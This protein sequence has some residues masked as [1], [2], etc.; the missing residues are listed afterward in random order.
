MHVAIVAG[1]ASGDILGAGLIRS[2]K[3]KYPEASFE[4][5]A[6]PL[7]QAEGCKSFFSME[8]LAVMG[9]FNVLLRVP[10]L[11]LLRLQLIKRWKKKPPDLFI[12]IDAPEFNTGLELQLKKHGILTCH[13]VSPSV[14]AWRSNRIHKIKQAVDL[15]LVLFPFEE[16]FYLDHHLRVSCVGHPLADQIPLENDKLLARSKLNISE[17]DQVLAVL[18]GSRMSE[19]KML[20]KLFFEVAQ[21]CRDKLPEL[22]IIVPCVNEKIR[23]ELQQYEAQIPGLTVKYFDSHQ[24][25]KVMIASDSVL[26]AS[27]TATL[28]A[29]LLKKPMVV[30]YKVSQLTY[31]LAKHLVKIDKFAIPNL[32][33]KKP[34]VPE[35]IQDEANPLV[36][37]DSVLDTFRQDTTKDTIHAFHNVHT[38]LKRNADQKAAE[39]ISCLLEEKSNENCR[40]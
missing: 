30:A 4:G 7:M 8:K 13:Y 6:G 24:N 19:V 36:I 1:E 21:L 28:E 31:M 26:L 18:P 37:A 40:C 11:Y 3:Q 27:G 16:K 20:G 2:L 15:M 29:T 35:F 5:I 38:L 34:L 22:K 32:L 17:K 10:D 9:I 14:W 12:G 25:R 33:T 39:A 23:R